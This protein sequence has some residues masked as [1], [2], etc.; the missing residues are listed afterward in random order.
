MPLVIFQHVRRF[1]HSLLEPAPSGDFG[2][3]TESARTSPNVAVRSA[4]GRRIVPARSSTPLKGRPFAERTA[5]L[6]RS[7][8]ATGAAPEC[9]IALGEGGSGGGSTGAA[10]GSRATPVW[11]E[12]LA[13]SWRLAAQQNRQFKSPPNHGSIATV[14]RPSAAPP[15]PS[16]PGGMM[17]RSGRRDKMRWN[18]PDQKS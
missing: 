12:F 1:W 16:T 13:A 9:L 17:P 6:G 8:L 11:A 2:R 5:T 15:R 10:P 14:C 18:P 3:A 4:N 7:R